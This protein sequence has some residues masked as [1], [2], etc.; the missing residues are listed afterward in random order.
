MIKSHFSNLFN[1][2]VYHGQG[3]RKNFFEGWFFKLVSPD[4][5]HVYSI[6]PGIFFGRKRTSA[7]AFIQVMNGKTGK[8]N[9]H[10]YTTKEFTSARNIFDIQIA[11]NRF[12]Q[13]EIIL[14]IANEDQKIQ[15]VLQFSNL[16]P[17]PVT[18]RSPGI[19]GWYAY[20]PFMECNHG[21]VSLDHTIEGSLSIDS[22]KIDF[23][24]GKGYIEKDWGKSFPEAWIWI[25]SNHFNVPNTS[26]TASVAKI[27]WLFSSFRG[28]IVGFLYKGKLFRFAT[29]TGAKI[30]GLKLM[31]DYVMMTIED[32]LHRLSIKT[33]RGTTGILYSPHRTDMLERTAES[34]QAVTEVHLERLAPNNTTIFQG[35][36]YHTGLDINGNIDLILDGVE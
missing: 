4:D 10:R 31:K 1:P 16:S 34:L 6:I 19:M 23:T 5:N 11:T 7:H 33:Q 29:Y 8:T 22:K 27:P 17:W 26:L 13:D 3:K 25:Q 32:K 2:A 18:L 21:V 14:D 20:V 12:K 9:Y 24:G 15:G 28:F 30:T 36:G 35:T